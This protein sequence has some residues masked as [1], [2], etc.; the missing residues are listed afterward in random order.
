MSSNFNLLTSQQHHVETIS[1]CPDI[2]WKG[3]GKLSLGYL[4]RTVATQLANQLILPLLHLVHHTISATKNN[5]FDVAR[6]L[7]RALITGAHS[8]TSHR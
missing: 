5:I 4:K 1:I 6:V 7:F 3:L 2:C 8:L